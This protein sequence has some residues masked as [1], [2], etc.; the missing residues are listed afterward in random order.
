MSQMKLLTVR[1]SLTEFE[2]VRHGGGPGNVA[3]PAFGFGIPVSA[4]GGTDLV[5]AQKPGL[6]TRVWSKLRDK[7]PWQVPVGYEDEAGFH[8]GIAPA[9]LVD[10]AKLAN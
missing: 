8:Y 3:L 10:V 4:G 1:R 7:S 2:N 9:R 6:M 5:R